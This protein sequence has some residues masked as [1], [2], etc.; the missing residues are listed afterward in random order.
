MC[1]DN[2]QWCCPCGCCEKW[3]GRREKCCLTTWR[4]E[5]SLCSFWT[6]PLSVSGGGGWAALWDHSHYVG[7]FTEGKKRSCF[8]EVLRA[9]AILLTCVWYS[10]RKS[11]CLRMEEACL[12][13]A[14]VCVCGGIRVQFGLCPVPEPQVNISSQVIISL[15]LSI[16]HDFTPKAT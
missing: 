12:Q 13:S 7:I 8:G 4:W 2:N 11:V 1:C 10:L 6:G 3:W 16:I 9:A 14:Y 5:G 15:W